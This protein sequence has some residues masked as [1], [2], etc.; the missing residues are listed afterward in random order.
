MPS[1]EVYLGASRI[2]SGMSGLPGLSKKKELEIYTLSDSRGPRHTIFLTLDESTLLRLTQLSVRCRVVEK[3]EFY[4][5]IP[6]TLS[7]LL[8]FLSSNILFPPASFFFLLLLLFCFTCCF[9]F[10]LHKGKHVA[11]FSFFLSSFF[12]TCIFLP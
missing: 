5:F 3:S 10:V 11:Y 4:Y 2:S 12:F 6:L 1:A 7:S 8:Y 9:F